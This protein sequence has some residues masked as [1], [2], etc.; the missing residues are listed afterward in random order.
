MSSDPDLLELA[1]KVAGSAGRG[2]QIEAYVA[3]SRSAS[4]KVH[5]GEVESLTQAASAGIG[6]RVVRDHRQGFAWAASLDDDVVAD[7]VADARDNAAFAEPD[8]WVGLAEPDGVAPPD[9]DLWREGL[10]ALPTERKVTLALELE[11]AVRAGD[12]RITGVRNAT[13]G[14]SLGE[15][16]VATSTGIEAWG[17]GTGC[18]LAVTALAEEA[19]ETQTGYGVSVG[20]A[21]DDI[22]LAEAATDAVDRATRLLGAKQPASGV[23]TLVLEPRM[24]ATLVALAAGMLNGEAVLKGRSPFADRVGEAIAAPRLSLVDD[25]TD[26]LSLGADTHDGEGL[27]T[28]RIQLIDAG[29][30]LGF[31]HNTYTAR[32]AGTTSTASAVRGYRSTPGVGAQALA[33]AP[34]E[35]SLDELIAQVDHGVLVQSMSGVHSGVNVISGDFS[36]GVE[37]LLIRGGAPA[38]PVRE[39]TIASTIQRLLLDVRLVGADQERTPGGITAS[40]LVIDNVTL[41]GA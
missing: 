32:R 27:G 19:G 16:A 6:V 12:P 30:L 28:R 31:L 38:E 2:E 4:V 10:D 23:V 14:D 24:A 1:R 36:V 41:S 18:H 5:G 39:A 15:G 17:R 11:G 3:R 8:E 25:P 22:D 21:P 13:W 33:L 34:G 35:G 9:L 20:R 29:V 7:V 40:P 26:P 37:G